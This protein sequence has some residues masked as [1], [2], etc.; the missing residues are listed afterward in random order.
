MLKQLLLAITICSF[1]TVKATE[2]IEISSTPTLPMANLIQNGSFDTGLKPWVIFPKDKITKDSGVKQ[3]TG[4]KG[5]NCLQLTGDTKTS[6]GI[7]QLVVLKSTLPAG[8]PICS[9][10]IMKSVEQ[11]N[12]LTKPS[13]VIRVYHQDNSASYLT[14][15]PLP[16]EAHDWLK[17]GATVFSDKPIKSIL[18]YFCYYKQDGFSQWDDLVIKAGWVKLKVNITA[19]KLKQVKVYGQLQH[20]IFDSGILPAGTTNFTK[21]L[22]VYPMGGYCVETV[23]TANEVTRKFYPASSAPKNNKSGLVSL[24]PRFNEEQIKQGK[25]LKLTFNAPKTKEQICLSFNIRAGCKT[26]VA[27]WSNGALKIKLNGQAVNPERLIGRKQIF[28]RANGTTGRIG[29]DSFIAFYAPWCFNIDIENPYCPV[30]VKDHNPFKYTLDITNLLKPG[31]NRLEF[32]NNAR[33]SPKFKV[34][35]YLSDAVIF[36]Q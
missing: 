24:M 32:Y 25:T 7:K 1:T 22:Q 10:F 36:T 12:S 26:D 3:A 2:Q 16:N 29:K 19:Q 5:D 33:I 8:A 30:D 11:D 18:Y 31:A 20:L 9:S 4:S 14:A 27:G 13:A 23:N 34:N 15:P 17:T 28:T 21:E 35:L 6:I